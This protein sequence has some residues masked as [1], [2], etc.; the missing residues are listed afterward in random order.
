[1]NPKDCLIGDVLMCIVILTAW[2]YCYFLD[3]IDD[4]LCIVKSINYKFISEIVHVSQI[5]Q[6]LSDVLM[7]L[8]MF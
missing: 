5:I 7:Y 2:M 8:V 6:Y 1:M 4:I 3:A